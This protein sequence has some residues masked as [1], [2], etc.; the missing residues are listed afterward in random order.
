MEKELEQALESVA[1][2]LESL[3]S[4]AEQTRMKLAE[5]EENPAQL[6]AGSSPDEPNT[7]T[8]LAELETKVAKLE[9]EVE[10]TG[11]ERASQWLSETK[12][13][14]P[15]M[16]DETFTQIVADAGKAHLLQATPVEEEKEPEIRKGKIDE[17]G[18]KY[19]PNLDLSYKK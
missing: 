1:D 14:L 19:L 18:F 8:R 3:E 10:P 17:P 13:L 6:S 12:R 7:E 2:R 11:E 4:S 16:S 5:L 9:E 15:K